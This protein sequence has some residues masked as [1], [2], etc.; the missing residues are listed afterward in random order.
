MEIEALHDWIGSDNHVFLWPPP[1]KEVRQTTSKEV[2][3]EN[4][5]RR[6]VFGTRHGSTELVQYWDELSQSY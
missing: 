4:G 1:L 5:T 6:T 3:N 2:L